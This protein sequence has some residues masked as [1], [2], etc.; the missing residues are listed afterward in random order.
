MILARFL[1]FLKGIHFRKSLTEF[2]RSNR[3]L[4]EIFLKIIE[5]VGYNQIL[6]NIIAY[7]FREQ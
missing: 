5:H 4:L 2:E 6:Q 7:I 1:R 3:F